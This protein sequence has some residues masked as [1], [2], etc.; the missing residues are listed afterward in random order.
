MEIFKVIDYS[1]SRVGTRKEGKSVRSKIEIKV[2]ELPYGERLILDLE[3]IELMGYS[4]ADEAIAITFQ[5][6]ISNEYG[7]KYILIKCLNA[8]ILEGLDVALKNRILTAIVLK[9]GNWSCI[10]IKKSHLINTLM[11]INKEREISTPELTK[12]LNNTA[13]NPKDKISEPNCN[14]RVTEL[15]RMKLIKREKITNPVG[16]IL[17]LNKSIV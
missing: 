15:A 16:G 5:R 11:L 4:F 14:N 7:D 2:K 13:T 12:V 8:D 9:N 17:Y 6:L 10:G 3:G 1:A